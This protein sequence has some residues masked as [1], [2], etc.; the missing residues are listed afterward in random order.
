MYKRVE[1]RYHGTGTGTGT[2]VVRPK[3]AGSAVEIGCR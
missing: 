1:H 2:G 3:I